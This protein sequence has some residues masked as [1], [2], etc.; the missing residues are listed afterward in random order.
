MTLSSDHP[1]YI[2][3][4]HA[5]SLG[6]ARRQAGRRGREK[7]E[8]HGGRVE[9]GVKQ[10]GQGDSRG[11]GARRQAGGRDQ[12]GRVGGVKGQT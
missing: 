5:P 4:L 6:G 7:G 10:S 12:G 8:S 2:C 11:R 9:E 3:S 1:S